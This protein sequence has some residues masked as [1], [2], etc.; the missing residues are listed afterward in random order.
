VKSN[1]QY[2]IEEDKCLHTNGRLEN[3]LVK[4]FILMW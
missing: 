3:G 1:I 2:L 4:L